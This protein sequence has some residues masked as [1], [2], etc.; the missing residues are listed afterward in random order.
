M[1]TKDEEAGLSTNGQSANNIEPISKSPQQ[2]PKIELH[3]AFY[4]GYTPS[5]R[6]NLLLTRVQSMDLLQW[7]RDPIQQMGPRYSWIPYSPVL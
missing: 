2:Q 4:V 3:P 7:I 6:P 5:P 1:T